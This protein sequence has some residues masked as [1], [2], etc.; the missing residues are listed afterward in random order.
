MK[1][2]IVIAAFPKRSYGFIH[3]D[4]TGEE[5]FAH[6]SDFPDRTVLPV[7]VL[8]EFEIGAFKNRPKAV[9]VRP[10]VSNSASS[11]ENY[12]VRQ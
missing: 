9:K 3:D 1:K 2:G 4:E 12:E 6:A 11:A 10:L 8:V 5:I 7:G